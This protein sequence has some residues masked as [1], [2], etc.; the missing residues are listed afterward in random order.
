MSL[1][2][3]KLEKMIS[4]N[5]FAPIRYLV[6]H[7]LV[8]YI[9]LISIETADE[10]LLY[11][12]S[13][14]EFKIN[15]DNKNVYKLKSLRIDMDNNILDKYT[16]NIKNDN[17]EN[18]YREINDVVSP[19]HN[20]D[21]IEPYLENKYKKDINV[22]DISETD[23]KI[24]KENYRQLNRLKFCVQ[25][26]NYKISILF[27]NYICTLKR[28]DDIVCFYIR[29]YKGYNKTKIFITADL[30]LFYNK[31]EHIIEHLSII[32]KGIYDIIDKNQFRHTNTFNSLLNNKKII[33]ILSTRL[34]NKK[35]EYEDH[36]KDCKFMLKHTNKG[37]QNILININNAKEK[38]NNSKGLNKD[39]EYSYEISKYEEK[40]KDVEG[41][42]EEI[43]KTI[44]ELQGKREHIM[45]KV[46]KIMFDNNVMVECVIRNFAEL[47]EI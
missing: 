45:L 18:I 43:L 2:L 21:N 10:F 16:G 31:N 19:T 40:L 30:E 38:Y 33:T 8:M 25:N 47:K 11:I 32:R 44:L 17:I 20:N 41:I 24:I 22:S 3:E 7:K 9:E 15:T 14:Y 34:Q 39:I 1:S 29:N 26:M 4:K 6:Y 13:K 36:I 37:I 5:G 23:M 46:D 27:K 28:N 35:K 12:P 42:K